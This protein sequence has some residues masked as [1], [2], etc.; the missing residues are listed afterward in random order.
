VFGEKWKYNRKF[1]PKPIMDFFMKTLRLPLIIF[2][3]ELYT[4]LPLNHGHLTVVFGKAIAVEKDDNP[5]DQ[6]IDKLADEFYGQMKTIFEE[7]K[8]N[9]GYDD[10]EKLTIKVEEERK[11]T[12]RAQTPL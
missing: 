5:P 3:G 10:D 1:L 11:S 4:W 7:H 8:K 2:F 12:P 6:Y 9:L